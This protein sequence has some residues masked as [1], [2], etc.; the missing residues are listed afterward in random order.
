MN[1]SR[2]LSLNL[3][4]EALLLQSS[5]QEEPLLVRLSEEQLEL[6][7]ISTRTMILPNL[8]PEY[9]NHDEEVKLEEVS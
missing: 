7:A 9:Y 3:R 5:I 2:W 6:L 8:S 4:L 1:K